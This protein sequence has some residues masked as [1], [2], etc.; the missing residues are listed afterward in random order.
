MCVK[1]TIYKS[2]VIQLT[3]QM[4]SDWKKMFM[5]PNSS[6]QLR[7]DI[8]KPENR[9]DSIFR[10][11]W[12]LTSLSKISLLYRSGQFYCYMCTTLFVKPEYQ[13]KSNLNR[14]QTHNVSPLKVLNSLIS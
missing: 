6:N 13:E 11:L 9:R 8:R 14:I 1:E 12:G 2:S 4:S 3:S 7:P 10:W 5:N